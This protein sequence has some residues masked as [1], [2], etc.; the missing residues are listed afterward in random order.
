MSKYSLFARNTC[1]DVFLHYCETQGADL[2]KLA[3]KFGDLLTPGPGIHYSNFNHM[4]S[5]YEDLA[6]QCEDPHFGLNWS[7]AQPDDFRH[8]GPIMH[9]LNQMASTRGL[10][11]LTAD[12]LKSFTNGFRF[13]ATEDQDNNLVIIKC[14]IHPKADKCLQL[15]E[16]Y[17]G[18]LAQITRI[19]VKDFKFSQVCFQH[20]AVPSNTLYEK[21]FDAPIV[22]NSKENLLVFDDSY[23]N[24]NRIDAG[25]FVRKALNA[26]L[27]YQLKRDK[28]TASSLSV[29]VLGIISELLGTGQ[30]DMKSVAN[31]LGFSP[32]K[33]Q[34]SLKQENTS[35][36]Q[37]LDRA[38][39]QLATKYL[40]E[41]TTSLSMIALMLDYSSQETF[42]QAFY[43]WYDQSPTCFRDNNM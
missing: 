13:S 38:R 2:E 10:V 29:T 19:M 14:S 34:R 21:V 5:L 18:T 37:L 24:R 27:D 42:I 11:Y 20:N 3:Q 17:M 25:P 33:L 4:A 1:S 16:H 41:S 43:R 31:F 9:V 36:S 22:F 15:M 8:A 35:F 23:L 28:L 7:L 40:S 12:Y 32:K 6:K 30:T 39:K 26:Y